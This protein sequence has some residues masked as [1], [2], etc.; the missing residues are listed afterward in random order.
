MSLISKLEKALYIDQDFIMESTKGMYD[1]DIEA[2]KDYLASSDLPQEEIVARVEKAT[3]YANGAVKLA[4]EATVAQVVYDN[5]I[6][7]GVSVAEIEQYVEFIGSDL[8]KRIEDIVDASFSEHAQATVEMLD[9]LAM[10]IGLIE[11]TR[12]L[13]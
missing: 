11:D 13:N 6:K 2:L 7:R 5:L 12:K 9:N 3:A 10:S 1:S 8:Y 4:G